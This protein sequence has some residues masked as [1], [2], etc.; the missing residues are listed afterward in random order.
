MLWWRPCLCCTIISLFLEAKAFSLVAAVA[1]WE[2][3][4]GQIR[5]L[6]RPSAGREGAEDGPVIEEGFE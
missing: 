2:E 6:Q 5:R 3:D 1:K 4:S